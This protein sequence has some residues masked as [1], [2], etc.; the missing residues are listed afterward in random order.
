MLTEQAPSTD[1]KPVQTAT[2]QKHSNQPHDENYSE[3]K[4]ILLHCDPIQSLELQLRQIHS[5]LEHDE[6]SILNPLES[7]HLLGTCSE[8]G[9]G[10]WT[11]VRTLDCGYVV[12]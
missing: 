7:G 1:S 12:A 2:H 3:K 6:I 11:K 4:S 9:K 5:F 10:L 8:P